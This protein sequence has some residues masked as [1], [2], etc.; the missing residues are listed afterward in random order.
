[1]NVGTEDCP[2]GHESGKRA[3]G[4][5]R[6]HDGPAE[7]EPKDEAG[8]GVGRAIA[9]QGRERGGEDDEPDDDPAAGRLP[10]GL[11]DGAK[12]LEDIVRVDEKGDGEDGQADQAEKHEEAVEGGEE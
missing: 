2:A 9:D 7:G 6:G 4:G 10:P 12:G 8:D 11:G 5:S 1:M 3:N